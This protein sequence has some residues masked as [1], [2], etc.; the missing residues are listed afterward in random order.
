MI[1]NSKLQALLQEV[2]HK[3]ER[4]Q[5]KKKTG[6]TGEE[7]TKKRKKNRDGQRKEWER[8]MSYSTR[9]IK[10]SLDS[11]GSSSIVSSD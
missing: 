5:K 3:E 4:V 2:Q 7:E 1:P 8:T 6:R 10:E 11:S 9:I